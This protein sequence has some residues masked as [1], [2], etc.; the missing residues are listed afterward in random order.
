MATNGGFWPTNVTRL[1]NLADLADLP[2]R[3]T[4]VE[5][6]ESID[7]ATERILYGSV[8][9]AVTRSVRDVH[10]PAMLYGCLCHVCARFAPG[11]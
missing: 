11:G 7:L 9:T 10:T 2:A 4:C 8:I 6:G 1:T 5:C 3:L